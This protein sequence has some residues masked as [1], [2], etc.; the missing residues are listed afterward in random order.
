ME[1]KL[2][3]T[4]KLTTKDIVLMGVMLATIEAAKIAL[5]AIPG[6]EIM[7]IL[8]ILYTLTFGRK[9]YYV[10]GTFLLVEL[11]LNGLGIWW[12]MY[13]YLW[14]LLAFCTRLLRKNQSLLIWCVFSGLFGLF[15]GLLCSV[16]YFFVGGVKMAFS[17]WVSGIPTDITH[18]ISN[19]IVCLVLFT[20][21]KKALDTIA[22]STKLSDQDRW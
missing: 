15:F 17:W 2:Q 20:P 14:P 6:I 3:Q 4:K 16:P 19:F 22:R 18:G 8:I 21:L 13:L 7:T 5:S 9:I 1:E 10:L 12:F 11:C